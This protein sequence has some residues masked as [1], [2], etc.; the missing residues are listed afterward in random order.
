MKP[1]IPELKMDLSKLA[2]I[3][4]RTCNGN[5][6]INEMVLQMYYTILKVMKHLSILLHK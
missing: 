5:K 4:Y 6:T 2:L 1:D 3:D